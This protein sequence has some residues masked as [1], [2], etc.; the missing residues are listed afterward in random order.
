MFEI[1][2]RIFV[3][4]IVVV[5]FVIVEDMANNFIK[6]DMC[7]FFTRKQRTTYNLIQK[8][9]GVLLVLLSYLII[10]KW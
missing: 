3:A 7:K 6:I 2:G 1:I 5:L 9:T 4:F 10:F 8:T